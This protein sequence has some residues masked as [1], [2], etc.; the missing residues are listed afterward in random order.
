M[1]IAATSQAL[2]DPEPDWD[3]HDPEG[4]GGACERT[5][6]PAAT[7]AREAGDLQGAAQ[8]YDAVLA[9]APDNIDAIAGLADILHGNGGVIS[10]HCTLILGRGGGA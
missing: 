3:D 5:A 10:V 4:D 6:D 8:I 1:A 7:E 2:D 9:Q